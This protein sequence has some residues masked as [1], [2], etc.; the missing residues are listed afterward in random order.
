MNTQQHTNEEAAAFFVK[1][2]NQRAII[3]AQEKYNAREKACAVKKSENEEH[4]N[5]IIQQ[6]TQLFMARQQHEECPKTSDAI[7]IDQLEEAILKKFPLNENRWLKDPVNAGNQ[8]PTF[9]DEVIRQLVAALAKTGGLV[10]F[11]YR[12]G[13]DDTK[14]L[15]QIG[16]DILQ[17]YERVTFQRYNIAN[18]M[19]PTHQVSEND[20]QSELILDDYQLQGIGRARK[21]KQHYTDVHFWKPQVEAMFPAAMA[22]VKQQNTTT[23]LLP[24]NGVDSGAE[25][26]EIQKTTGSRRG[27]K[28]DSRMPAYYE[29]I[30]I[31]SPSPPDDIR[32]AFQAMQTTRLAQKIQG[33]LE[34]RGFKGENLPHKDTVEEWLRKKFYL[35]ISM[36]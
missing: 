26:K 1:E 6:S 15:Q 36:T 10:L 32:L 19:Y 20:K 8:I 22:D 35:E 30:K 14:G 17:D 21:E 11:G 25:A 33:E 12:V 24:I 23:P 29:A 27:R 4:T 9:L 16:S 7:S 18:R 5:K 3:E 34:K 2:A 13:G 31:L 28:P